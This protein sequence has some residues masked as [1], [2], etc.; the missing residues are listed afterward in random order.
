MLALPEQP[1][2]LEAADGQSFAALGP[3]AVVSFPQVLLLAPEILLK[4]GLRLGLEG[5]P[6]VVQLRALHQCRLGCFHPLLEVSFELGGGC[7][8]ARSMDRGQSSIKLGRVEG[9]LSV[10]VAG[11]RPVPGQ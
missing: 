8:F 10:L 11:M 5:N 7:L 9:E 4:G 3:H 1:Q 6:L 2:D